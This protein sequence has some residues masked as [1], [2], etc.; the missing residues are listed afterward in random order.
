[1]N[2]NKTVYDYTTILASLQQIAP[3]AHIAGGA[4]RDTILEKPIH[5]IDVFMADEHVEAAAACLRMTHSYVKV[6]EWTRY[7]GFSDPAMSRVAK[8][9]KADETIPICVIG[10]RPDYAEPREN[11]AR[12]DF[13]VC[14]TA[15]DGETTIR[16]D[17]FERDVAG[18]TFTLTRADN[19]EQFAYSMSRF[20]KITAGRY[21]GWTL[22]IPEEFKEFAKER[23]F[24]E[25]F[26]WENIKGLDGEFVL[27]PKERAFP[28]VN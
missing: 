16:T 2:A 15:F 3:E 8:F 12:F 13:G 26:Y 19:K 10:L 28:A 20:D 18:Q 4:V 27:K 14:M 5:D 1:M 9:E 6:G 23:A 7:E 25:Y 11:I 24:R 17:E 22:A 21:L